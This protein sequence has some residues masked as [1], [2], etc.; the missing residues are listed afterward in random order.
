MNFKIE[1]LKDKTPKDIE[2][3]LNDLKREFPLIIRLIQRRMAETV[4]RT[5]QEKYLNTSGGETLRS[6]G[7]T[8]SSSLRWWFV[9]NDIFVGTNLIYAA[10]HEYGGIIRAKNAPFLVFFYNGQWYRKKQVTIP[11][12]AYLRPSIDE[13]FKTDQY[14]RIAELTLNQELKKRS[15]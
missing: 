3:I 14:K 11:Q 15:A 8:L 4:I 1:Y 9:G 2:K 12:R 5:A 13:L 7:G 6:R 10:I